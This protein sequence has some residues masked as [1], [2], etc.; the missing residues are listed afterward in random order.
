MINP[1]KIEKRKEEDILAQIQE[2]VP[3]YVPEW[4]PTQKK[5]ADTALLKIFSTMLDIIAQ[6]LNKTPDK[7]F[8]AF[9]DM[10]GLKLLP[11]QPAKAPI[12]F[13]LAE[14]AK[15]NVL[16]AE[17]AQAAAG[18]VI[19]ETEKTFVAT[20]SKIVKI[21][22]VS[23]DKI[24]ATPQNIIIGESPPPFSTKLLY[25]TGETETNIFLE[26][27]IGLE[28][29]DI[30]KVGEECYTI[31]LDIKDSK[32]TLPEGIV[33]KAGASVEKITN[34]EAFHGKNLQEH[35]LYLGHNALFNIKG[36]T[37]ISLSIDENLL[38]SATSP[39]P[40]IV[41]WEYWGEETK[42]AGWHPLNHEIKG[43]NLSLTIKNGATTECEIKECE[44]NGIKSRWIRCKIIG[45]YK[46]VWVPSGIEPP[47]TPTDKP[48]SPA[49]GVEEKEPSLSIK[50]NLG[51]AEGLEALYAML[52]PDSYKHYLGTAI[53]TH[54]AISIEAALKAPA[55][56]FYPDMAFYNNVPLDIEFK[57][58]Q[59]PF[60]VVPKVY[61]TFY[62]A[63][64]E[65]FSKKKGTVTLSIT[66]K[67][68]QGATPG[69]TAKLSWEYWNGN[70]WVKLSNV[71][72]KTDPFKVLKEPDS[73]DNLI[74]IT[75]NAPEDIQETKVNGH[76]NYW[77]RIK[78]IGGDYGKDPYLKGIDVKDIE[79]LTNIID[80]NDINVPDAYKDIMQK[81]CVTPPKISLL[82][83]S[84]SLDPQ[85]LEHRLTYNNLTYKDET[86]E[87]K[88]TDTSL[89]PFETLDDEHNTL[90]FGFDKKPE[91]GPIS[92]FFD[93][94]EP[95]IF[96][97]RV[98]IEWEY[99]AENDGAPIWNALEVL[100]GTNGFVQSGTVELAFSEDFV[101]TNRFG[102]ELYWIR[103]V[104]VN[105]KF[106][107]DG[108]VPKPKIK[109]VHLNTT[110]SI[111][112][113]TIKDELL[114]S[115]NGNA[116]QKF[117]FSK[118]PVFSSEVW[119]NEIN[120]IS[121]G[122]RTKML[123]EA[124][125]LTKE[126]RDG[127]GN[128]TEFWVRWSPVNDLLA[129]SKDDRKYEI[130]GAAGYIIFGNGE[131]GRIPPIGI[132]NIKTTYS[133]GGGRKGNV[134]NSEIV[135]LKTSIAF[136]DKVFNPVSSGGGSEKEAIEEAIERGCQ[137]VRNRGRAITQKDYE[138]LVREASR[139]V[140]RV[141]CIPNIDNVWKFN[142]GWVTVIIV[143][144]TS[145]DKPTP[146][147]EL[148]HQVKL[149]L[150]ENMSGTVSVPGRLQVSR[151]LYVR[152]SVETKIIAESM[153][154]IP[155]IEKDANSEL[156]EFLH[157]LR[158]GYEGNGWEFGRLPY[159]S[160]FYLLLE[161]IKGVDY[162]DFLSVTLHDID[163]NLEFSLSSIDE[164]TEIQPYKMIY[165][166]IHK[167][168]VITNKTGSDKKEGA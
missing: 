36:T 51:T 146:S 114:G 112:S 31:V 117:L 167:I 143:P 102:E 29:G 144:Y 140:A 64:Q 126:V 156:K 50:E 93:I 131:H 42:K 162:V 80:V 62:I 157:P 32:V 150:T 125:P 46:D 28:K 61:D 95:K 59:F 37:T 168:N 82:E 70:G 165:S 134:N 141:K 21:Y 138:Y 136:V 109:G 155:F 18:E 52:L 49:T 23:G 55:N 152:V 127:K 14:G 111:Q 66:G 34:L 12:T 53:S 68:D 39:S 128:V 3:F 84:Y 106:T 10:L 129:S 133:T 85:P 17:R 89:A 105:D 38:T 20:P 71:D 72:N 67:I 96:V 115:S 164:E 24:F 74:N 33:G 160:D 135:T 97:E 57:E 58:E 15:Q 65:A 86:D 35:I 19:F 124:E 13:I 30:I 101:K 103:A 147:L 142:P 22:S 153:E 151:P 154:H 1:P 90:Y 79:D 104:D 75:F 113:E 16:V 43:D 5:G 73:E 78:L 122:E 108:A 41:K 98:R 44:V 119:V 76:K 4:D 87:A 25:S 123:K 91:K 158:G 60:G 92:I 163:Q 77:I 47:T 137:Y 148:R 45:D 11:P 9:L 63:S 139:D 7:N 100:D 120:A 121:D 48:A 27:T 8:I 118:L 99:P 26:S 2:L 94:E 130:D 107:T 81:G 88:K 116:D 56:A 161:R 145:E 83:I 110:W 40:N 69:I 6:R 132:D 149:F 166:G 159:F 54:E